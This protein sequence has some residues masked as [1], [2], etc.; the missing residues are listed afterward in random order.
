VFVLMASGLKLLNIS[1]SDLGIILLAAAITGPAIWAMIRVS[2]GYSWRGGAARPA[3]SCAVPVS[4]KPTTVD[5][6]SP[7]A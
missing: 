1:T 2:H 6:K 4:R 7:A 5:S 3:V